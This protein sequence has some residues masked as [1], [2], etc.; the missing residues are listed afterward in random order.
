MNEL[1][2]ITTHRHQTNVRF[3]S[4]KSNLF[5]GYSLDSTL[6]V[7]D[8]Y[9]KSSQVAPPNSKVIYVYSTE[10][11]KE[12]GSFVDYFRQIQSLFSMPPTT[13]VAIG[14]GVVQDTAS[15]IAGLI[16]RGIHFVLVPTTFAAQADS[17]IGSKVSINLNGLKN[18]L[19]F[20]YPPNDVF[21]D[22]SFLQTLPY[23][24][25]YTGAG[26][27]IH[28]LAQKFNSLDPSVVD[29]LRLFSSNLVS[30]K[31]PSNDV[32]SGL[33]LASLNI[34]KKFIE[35]D[36]FDSALR[37]CLNFGHTFGHAIEMATDFKISHGVAVLIGMEMSL[38]FSSSILLENTSQLL[39]EIIQTLLASIPSNINLSG[40]N[41]S[42]SK[43][44]SSIQS[45]KKNRSMS[46][47]GLILFSPSMSLNSSLTD[48]ALL[49]T[50]T[51][52]VANFAT[53]YFNSSTIL[54]LQP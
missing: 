31:V 5:V 27:I 21:I 54:N 10:E 33:I 28:Y 38:Q 11:A 7:I 12:F 2:S 3:S 47:V 19:G 40:V 1:L 51:L 30:K 49:P 23:Y 20:F 34:K 6:F 48:M 13:V 32:I 17:C 9:F 52:A 37:K 22:T 18:Q 53:N 42:F 26:E 24:E 46:Q 35:I 41:I 36:E 50:E 15:F 39:S 8:S 14:G 29:L 45:D 25:F 43:F 44:K 4:V 16:R